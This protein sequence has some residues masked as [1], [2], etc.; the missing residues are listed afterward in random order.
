[1]NTSGHVSIITDAD[2]DKIVII[3]DLR[4]KGRKKVDWN[5]V[6]NCLK[7]YIGTCTEILDTNELIYIGSDFP[8]EYTHSK[9]TKIL[10]GANEY[11]KANASAAI[12]ELIQV[13]VNKSFSE[14]YAKKHERNARFGWYRYDTKFAIPKYGNEGELAGY[15]I[16]KG[17]LVI[18]HAE[19]GKLYLYDILRIKK[20]TSKPLE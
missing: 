7:D 2:E 18:R 6:E 1:M 16:F 13:A 5:T 14:N 15:N 12:P 19:D 11:A 3:N 8:D 20:E 17:R 9:D 4:F 10:K